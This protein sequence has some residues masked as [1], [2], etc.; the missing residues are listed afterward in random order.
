MV[1]VPVY[2]ATKFQKTKDK[3]GINTVPDILS[4]LDVPKG[5]FFCP[6]LSLAQT[7]GW[8][9]IIFLPTF[10]LGSDQCGWRRNYFSA[11]F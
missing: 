11:H 8:E 4:T 2:I 10:E 3:L 6:P 7:S 5:L 1:P 9:R